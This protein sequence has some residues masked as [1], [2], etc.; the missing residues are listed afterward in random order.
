MLPTIRISALG[1]LQVVRD[2]HLV[3]EGDWHTRQARQAL[4]TMQ[5]VP[6][7]I[8]IHDLGDMQHAI[9]NERSCAN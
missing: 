8:A 9:R 2:N 5:V 6:F 4:S 3:T 7:I 1:T